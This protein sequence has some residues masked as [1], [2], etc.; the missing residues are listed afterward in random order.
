MARRM[1]IVT[2]LASV[3]KAFTFC[4]K[5]DILTHSKVN[6]TQETNYAK[7]LFGPA[8]SGTKGSGGGA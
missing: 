6:F 5:K 3:C 2:R 1:V 8:Y 7:Q 4:F